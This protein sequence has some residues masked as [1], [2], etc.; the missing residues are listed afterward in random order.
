[1]LFLRG[2]TK[3]LG[4]LSSSMAL[5]PSEKVPGRQSVILHALRERWQGQEARAA[6]LAPFA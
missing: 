2:M 6:P 5:R 4:R 3:L 1:M